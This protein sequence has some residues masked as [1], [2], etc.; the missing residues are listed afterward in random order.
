L[1]Q[2]VPQIAIPVTHDQPGVAARIAYKKTGK[3]ISLDG[4]DPLRLSDHLDEVLN[5]PIYRDNSRSI[6]KAIAKNNGLSVAADLL[7]Q[8]FGLTKK[9]EYL[10]QKAI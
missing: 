9:T 5:N 4:L 3:T 6:Q 8:A 7:E 2:G 10:P 1:A